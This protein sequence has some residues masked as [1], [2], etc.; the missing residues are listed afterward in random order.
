MKEI[1]VWRNATEE[2]A[3]VFIKKYFPDERYAIDTFW[4]ADRVGDVFCVADYF[5]NIDRMIEAIELK[6]TSKQLNDFYNMELDCGMRDAPLPINF[7]NYLKLG[8][9]AAKKLIEDNEKNL[10]MSST[11]G[12]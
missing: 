5:Y 7:R 4:V 3:K 2:V 6:A 12:V 9:G 1:K 10:L 8:K 11:K